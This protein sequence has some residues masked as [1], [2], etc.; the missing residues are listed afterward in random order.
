MPV[1]HCWDCLE[2]K[3]E[4]LYQSRFR[5]SALSNRSGLES[6]RSWTL[7]EVE[8]QAQMYCQF[9]GQ[10]LYLARRDFLPML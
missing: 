6:L 10:Q 1:L 9:A 7:V 2:L 3:A 5:C 8:V 4:F